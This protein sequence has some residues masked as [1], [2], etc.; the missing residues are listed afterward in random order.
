MSRKDCVSN[1]NTKIILTYLRNILG[2]LGNLLD[3]VDYPV[4]RYPDAE[5]YYLNEDEWDTLENYRTIYHRAKELVGDPN[6]FFNCGASSARYQS[7]GSLKY[8]K[9]ILAGPTMVYERVPTL[10]KNFND[11][12]EFDIIVKPHEEN[13]RIKATYRIKFHEDIDPHSD[14]CSD[15]HIRGIVASAPEVWGLDR[16]AVTQPLVE[17]DPLILLNREFDRFN[18]DARIMSGKLLITDPQSREPKT[19][20]REVFLVPETRPDKYADPSEEVFLGKY[21]ETGDGPKAVMLTEDVVL[22]GEEVAKK[23]TLFKAPYF[24]INVECD[25][26]TLR[27]KAPYFLRFGMTK[28][29]LSDGLM[30]SFT[31]TRIAV[32]VRNEALEQLQKYATNLEGMVEQRTR[33]LRETQTQLIEVEKR[34]LEHRITGGFAHE[35]RNALAGAQL[36]CKTTLNYK[37]QGKPSAEILKDS[38]TS[39]LKN[40][41][42]IHEKYSVPREEIATLVLPELKTI[43]EIGDH[44]SGVHSGV[45]SDLNRGLS[46]TT[47]IRDYAR[48]S[49][50]KPGDQSIEVVQMLLGFGD[51]YRQDFGRIGITYSVEGIENAVVKADETHINSIFSNL[52]LNAKDALEEQGAEGKAIS[53]RVQR[54]DEVEASRLKIAVED[55]GPGIPEENLNEVFE[56]FFS[57][58]P[59]SGTG[60]GLGIVKRLVQLYGG[61][62]EVESEVGEGTRFSVTL[63]YCI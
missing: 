36:E 63:P 28:K 59:T 48:M 37:D 20:G 17:Y 22:D 1:R 3:G 42:L 18:L 38:A 43:A 8:F 56:P 45:S 24:I 55:N 12:K 61:E 60:L 40:I 29:E 14:Y 15:P 31:Q 5:S 19:I 27:Q 46:I 26:L 23:G 44:L 35:M 49:E 11:T 41:S 6:F 16:A 53:V 21:S 7:W 39:L 50:M 9:R 54:V 34:T 30:H 47:Q 2:D 57:T 4:D 58:K 25:V 13:G 32:K 52:I 33:E 62:I 51:R 10:N